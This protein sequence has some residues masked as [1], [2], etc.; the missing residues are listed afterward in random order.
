M[1]ISEQLQ[2]AEQACKWDEIRSRRFFRAW[3]A[4]FKIV[5]WRNGKEG[6]QNTKGKF[7]FYSESLLHHDPAA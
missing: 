4:H 7:S 3:P 2:L 6:E 5:C 1:R